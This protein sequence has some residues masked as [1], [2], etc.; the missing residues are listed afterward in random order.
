MKSA[1]QKAAST[2]KKDL[3]N[4]VNIRCMHKNDRQIENTEHTEEHLQ[5]VEAKF[6]ELPFKYFIATPTPNEP[7]S[8]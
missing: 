8:R 1:M 3:C 7:L 4:V 2:P 6:D 5:C